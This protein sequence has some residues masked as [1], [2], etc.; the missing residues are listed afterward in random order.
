[1]YSSSYSHFCCHPK[2]LGIVILTVHKGG[3]HIL[4]GG[5]VPP[6]ATLLDTPLD[7]CVLRHPG[8]WNWVWFESLFWGHKPLPPAVVYKSRTSEEIWLK[9]RVAITQMMTRGPAAR[10]SMISKDYCELWIMQSYSSGVQ[11][12]KNME[13]KMSKLCR[14]TL[15]FSCTGKVIWFILSNM[16]WVM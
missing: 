1:M 6:H 16:A 8:A 7:P 15:N 10:P 14:S 11:E 5:L 3:D 4:G 12:K 2:L 9:R 13:L